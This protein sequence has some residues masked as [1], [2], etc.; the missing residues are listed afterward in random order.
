M[1]WSRVTWVSSPLPEP[2]AAGVAHLEEVDP[3]PDAEEQGEGGGHALDGLLLG[4]PADVLV[5]LP[6]GLLQ[7]LGEGGLAAAALRA[8]VA[9][10]RLADIGGDGLDGEAARGLAMLGAAHAVGHHHDE[11][12]A[13]LTR[14]GVAALGEA[15]VLDVDAL[16]EGANEEVVL[17]GLSDQALMGEAVDVDLGVEGLAR[18]APCRGHGFVVNTG[19]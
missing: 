13:F 5:A 11:G 2:V 16:V 10:H 9:A 1:V 12:E 14:D 7:H 17:V 6:G 19:H 15:A 18:N 8:V 4:V 3:G